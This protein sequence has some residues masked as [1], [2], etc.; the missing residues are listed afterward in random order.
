MEKDITLD[1]FLIDLRKMI[2]RYEK[3]SKANIEWGSS[4]MWAGDWFE[5]FI[6]STAKPL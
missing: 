4:K 3:E 1:E 2:D 6:E 5:D